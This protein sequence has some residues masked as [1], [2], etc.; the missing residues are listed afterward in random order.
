MRISSPAFTEIRTGRGSDTGRRLQMGAADPA[1][2]PRPGRI[3]RGRDRQGRKDER[4]GQ[5]GGDAG[6]AIMAEHVRSPCWSS[7]V[8]PPIGMTGYVKQGACQSAE[9]AGIRRKCMFQKA[10]QAVKACQQVVKC[11]NNREWNAIPSS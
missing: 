6:E 9:R 5:G 4:G 2:R 7:L 8:P 10:L 1:G 3:G 11:A